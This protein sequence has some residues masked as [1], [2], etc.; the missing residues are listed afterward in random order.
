MKQ[1]KGVDSSN[2]S[3]QN[4]LTKNLTPICGKDAY[5]RKKFEKVDAFYTHHTRCL[6]PRLTVHLHG[7][8]LLCP[9]DD[10][11]AL[12]QPPAGRPQPSPDLAHVEAVL[13]P[14][15]FDQFVT[16]ICQVNSILFQH[17]VT[18]PPIH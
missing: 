12:G 8:P 4:I 2:E 15:D 9:D 16:N 13:Q 14:N 5:T 1:P 18:V 11:G 17:I 3:F 6:L 10:G 7:E